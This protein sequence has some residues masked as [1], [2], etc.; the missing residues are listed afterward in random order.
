[1][2]TFAPSSAAML[3]LVLYAAPAQGAARTWVSSAGGGATCSRA[4]PCATFQAAHDATD[5]GGEINCADAGDF[6]GVSINRAITIDCTGAS[7][8]TSPFGSDAVVVNAP[9]AAVTLRGLSLS[10]NG[11][12][13]FGVRFITGSVLT[14]ENVRLSGFRG[15]SPSCA[16]IGGDRAVA[17]QF[18]PSAGAAVLYVS[19]CTISD[20][21]FVAGG[22]GGGIFVKP[23]GSASARVVIERTR[24]ENNLLGI[25]LDGSGTTGWNVVQIGNSLVSGSTANGISVKQSGMIL[26]RTASKSNGGNGLLADVGAV[27]HLGYSTVTGNAFAGLA[28]NGGQIFS[29]Q[30]N[31]TKGNGADTAPSGVLTAN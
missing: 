29:Y 20:S 3:A 7:A 6:G 23:T 17:I 13:C 18:N 25:V 30:N 14:I 8:M 22:T 26:E 1:M 27:V 11:G 12:A 24:V 15:T 10:S 9:G 28:L 16:I 2:K 19:D 21:G 5:P 4:A 31:L